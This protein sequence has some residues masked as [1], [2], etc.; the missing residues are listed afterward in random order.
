MSDSWDELA[1]QSDVLHR[2]VRE[3]AL[4]A[5]SARDTCEMSPTAVRHSFADLACRIAEFQTGERFDDLAQVVSRALPSDCFRFGR[6]FR[7]PASRAA[8]AFKTSGTT[9]TGTGLHLMRDPRTYEQLALSWGKLALGLEQPPTPM[10]VALAPWTG[11]NTPSS[12]GYMM[13]RMMEQFDGKG[14]SRART[15]TAFELHDPLRW[16]VSERGVD[17]PGLRRIVEVAHSASTRV[18]LLA[19]SFALVELLDALG[20]DQLTLPA[21]STVMPT[22]GFKGRTRTIAPDVMSDELRRVFGDIDLVGEYGMTELSSQLY[23]GT[24]RWGSLV[25]GPGI[26]REPPWLRVVPCRP[27]TL[28]PVDEGEVGLACFVDLGNVDSAVAILTQDLVRREGGGIRLL[29]RQTTAPLRGCSL[30]IEALLHPSGTNRPSAPHLARAQRSAPNVCH[31]PLEDA[32]GRVVRLVEAAER[33]KLDLLQNELALAQI[34]SESFMSV[35]GVRL[36][37]EL[38]LETQPPSEDIT[39]LVTRARTLDFGTQPHEPTVW[40]ALSSTVFTAAHRA[41]ALALSISSRVLLKP[42]SR[43]PH[44]ARLLADAC[45]GLFEIV[46]QIAAQPEDLVMVFGSDE[47]IQA[48][49]Q[50]LPPTVGVRGFGHGMGV[51][52]VGADAN[53]MNAATGLAADMVLF[54]Q[55][56]CLSPRMVLVDASCDLEAFKRR[57]ELE[58]RHWDEVMP[59]RPQTREHAAHAAWERRVAQ[60][61]ARVTSCGSGWFAEYT[62]DWCKHHR[63]PL[64]STP[65]SIC[66]VHASA[67]LALLA[68]I[69]P[70]VTCVGFVG[71]EPLATALE[72]Q[73]PQARRVP[74]GSMQRPPFDGPVDLRFV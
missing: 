56:G 53:V 2:R 74:L 55:Q 45:D 7:F 18:V 40:V 30:A 58:L 63:L 65:R 25:G 5:L 29:G 12:L 51:A 21:G 13:Q 8:C 1:A 49:R 27:H 70:L 47:T 4:E 59:L 67:P 72:R 22:G 64:P 16:L 19:T 46:T 32:R 71:D 3:F 69:T 44:F 28:E 20:H 23:E 54:E 33:F 43:Q 31:E 34:A 62:E 42:S 35:A 17:V 68:P 14:L 61:F 37:L 66:V 73:F 50:S 11:P 36:A 15:A 24:A 6:V 48:V 26:Y 52:V 60:S 38:A 39:R 41:A 9:A 57:L 10:I